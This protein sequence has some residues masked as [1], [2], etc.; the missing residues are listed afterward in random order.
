MLPNHIKQAC[1]HL[2]E[3]EI[4]AKKGM[5]IKRGSGM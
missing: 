3:G 4:G 1:V 2:A 5:F